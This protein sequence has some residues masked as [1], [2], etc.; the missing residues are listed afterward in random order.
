[1]KTHIKQNLSF[2]LYISKLRF[3]KTFFL[4]F[5]FHMSILLFFPAVLF[6]CFFVSFFLT[7]RPIVDSRAIN[8]NET[9]LSSSTP[10]MTCFVSHKTTFLALSF[11][12]VLSSSPSFSYSH[13]LLISHCPPSVF[14]TTS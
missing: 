11:S 1:M 7:N 12:P 8:H 6:L 4:S 3:F 10:E 2:L 14:Y 9:N 5:N 13:K